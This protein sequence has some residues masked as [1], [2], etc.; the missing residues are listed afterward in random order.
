VASIQRYYNAVTITKAVERT[1]R[2]GEIERGISLLR[3]GSTMSL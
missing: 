1:T 2:V 3:S